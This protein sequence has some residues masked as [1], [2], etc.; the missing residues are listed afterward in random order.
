[1]LINSNWLLIVKIGLTALLLSSHFAFATSVLTDAQL[2]KF[3]ERLWQRE[4]GKSVAKLTSWNEGEAF[5]SLGIGHFIWYPA[6]TTGSYKETFPE[7]LDFL[8]Q[9]KVTLPS[10]LVQARINGCPWHTR[11]E[12]LAAQNSAQMNE[13]RSLLANTIKLQA[14]FVVERFLKT[15]DVLL[16]A[17]QRNERGHIAR[18]FDKLAQSPQGLF[19]LIDYVHFKGEGT[20]PTERHAGKGWGLLQVLQA[21]DD[22]AA[23]PLKEFITQAK[24]ILEQRVTLSPVEKGEKRWLTGW[25][26]RVAGY[27]DAL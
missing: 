16:A 5:P 18:Q 1:M 24:K 17:A 9:H 26:N 15:R 19:A 23:D 3:A 10:W 11:Q 20:Q 7:L 4:A 8:Q 25:L 27:A 12:F 6:G 14:E 22:K 21:M 13:L 2:N